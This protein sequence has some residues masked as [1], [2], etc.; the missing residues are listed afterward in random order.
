MTAVHKTGPFYQSPE[1]R[2]LAER[3]RT[4]RSTGRCCLCPRPVAKGERVADVVSGRGL[5]HL[6]CAGQL[7]AGEPR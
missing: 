3:A 5:A 1:P 4:A 2:L 6:S 7:A